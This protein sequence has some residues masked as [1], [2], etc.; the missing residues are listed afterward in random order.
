MGKWKRLLA[1]LEDWYICPTQAC[2]ETYCR[3]AGYSGK[4]SYFCLLV[5]CFVLFLFT[6]SQEKKRKL[7]TFSFQDMVTLLIS[8]N[9]AISGWQLGGKGPSNFP[10]PCLQ[11]KCGGGVLSGRFSLLCRKWGR[12]MRRDTKVILILQSLSK[13]NFIK[14]IIQESFGEKMKMAFIGLN[15]RRHLG[16]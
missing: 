4:I 10:S 3:K 14:V 2:P 11:H 7:P 16:K 13:I 8:A 15:E 9:R 5:F 6:C 12:N 1:E